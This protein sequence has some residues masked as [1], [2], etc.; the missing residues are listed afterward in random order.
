MGDLWV[1]TYSGSNDGTYED[2]V[3]FSDE[4]EGVFDNFDSAIN[5]VRKIANWYKA[6]HE[7]DPENYFEN[8]KEQE[9][10]GST[11]ISF[12]ASTKDDYNDWSYLYEIKKVE[13]NFLFAD[14]KVR[15][16]EGLVQGTK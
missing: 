10:Y 1:V 11:F 5:E 15:E 8:Y 16:L 3:C 6:K 7:E 12:D 4:F 14:A 13:I 2:F 9:K